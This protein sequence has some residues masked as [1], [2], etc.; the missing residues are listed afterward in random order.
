MPSLTVDPY[1]TH[2][3]ILRRMVNGVRPRRVLEF[4][5]GLHSTPLYFR[6]PQLWNVVC[7]EPDPEWRKK[8]AYAVDDER[9]ILREAATNVN[10][11]D[12]D[13]I[14]IDDGTCAAE[15]LK[16]IRFVLSEPHPPTVI[17]DAEVP[18]YRDAIKELA[19]MHTIYE[20][21]PHTAVVWS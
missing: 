12:F 6:D 16:T 15:R 8:V 4:G 19:T 9:L 11:T 14:F 3:P 7:I 5:A 13:L 1:S 21:N 18:E 17:H 2:L 10:P 20:T